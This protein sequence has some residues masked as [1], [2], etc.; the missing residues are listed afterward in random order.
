MGLQG[1]QM[2][3]GDQTLDKLIVG[4]MFVILQAAQEMLIKTW[5][6]VFLQESLV[7]WCPM[8]SWEFIC[9]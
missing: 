4:V 9:R 8:G 5:L 1:I 6:E 7:K 2:Q 3:L